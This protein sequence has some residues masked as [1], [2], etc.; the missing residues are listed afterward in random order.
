MNKWYI[1]PPP[2]V[3]IEGKVDNVVNAANGRTGLYFIVSYYTDGNG[4]EHSAFA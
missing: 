2:N 4:I 3:N 1:Q